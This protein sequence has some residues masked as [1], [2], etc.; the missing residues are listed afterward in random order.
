[1]LEFKGS[2]KK[3]DQT[4]PISVLVQFDGDVLYV[5]HQADPFYRIA[6][7]SDFSISTYQ[8]KSIGRIKLHNGGAIETKDLCVLEL[9]QGKTQ[10]VKNVTSFKF[11]RIRDTVIAAVLVILFFGVWLLTRN[12]LP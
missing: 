4:D 9:L 12:C 11:L 2:Y 6:T 5:W 10:L 1:M 3:R 8:K 7:C